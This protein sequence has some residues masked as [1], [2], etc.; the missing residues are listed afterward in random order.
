MRPIR[1]IL[2]TRRVTIRRAGPKLIK[3]LEKVTSYLVSGYY[4]SAAFKTRRWDGREHLLVFR[5][6]RYQV[7]IGLL[8]V[9]KR[10]LKRLKIPFEV[11]RRR[12]SAPPPVVFDWNPD[13]KLRPYQKRAA[14]AFCSVPERGRGILKMPVRSGKTKVAADII[15]RLGTRTLFLVPSQMLLHQTAESLSES[16]Q[17]ALIGKIGD[18]EW[19]E[20]EITVATIHTLARLRGGSKKACKGNR[21]RD[22]SG[23][24]V[25]GVYGDPAS[26]GRKKCDGAHNFIV[27][28]DPRYKPLIEG[29]GLVIMDECHHLRG[30]SWHAVITDI[31]ARYRLGLSATVYF[32]SAK[33]NERGVIWLRACCGEIKHE[34]DTSKLIEQGYLLRQHVKIYKVAKPN[35][36]NEPWSA[37]LRNRCIYENPYRNRLIIKLTQKRLKEG[38]NV[39]IITNRKNQIGILSDMLDDAGIPHTTLVGSDDRSTRAMRVEAFKDGDVSVIL[40][41]VFG[42]GVDIPEVECV[43][44]AEGGTDQKTTI[45]RMRNMTPSKGKT[46]AVLC[47]F[48]D[49][50]NQYFRKHS[51]ARMRT[52]ESEPAFVIKKMWERKDSTSDH[53]DGKPKP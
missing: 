7:P 11:K 47:D 46:K 37:E 4:F 30:D 41:T 35:A 16:L 32:N 53:R 40:G 15:R 48:W 42:E 38:M 13:T 51:R 3:Q 19:S 17:G 21:T 10:E 6:G 43:I 36:D 33:E 29:Y 31:P 5:R 44:N 8:A 27:K 9:I 50:T 39:M 23:N 49:D 18:G 52:Y 20:G 28:T 12:Q 14:D 24:W 45:Q 25:K 34:V 2:D 22:G 26:C 1:L